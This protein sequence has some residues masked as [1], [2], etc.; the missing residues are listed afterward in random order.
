MLGSS[1]DGL[2]GS[3]KTEDLIIQLEDSAT[4]EVKDLIAD[5]SFS[6]DSVRKI[7]LSSNLMDAEME[8]KFSFSDLHEWVL[9]LLAKDNPELAAKF[10]L[11][12]KFGDDSVFFDLNASINDLEGLGNLFVPGLGDLKKTDVILSFDNQRDHLSLALDAPHFDYKKIATDSLSIK[13]VSSNG[14]SEINIQTDSINTGGNLVIAPSE[15]DFRLT[16]NRL[17]Y[18]LISQSVGEHLTEISVEGNAQLKDDHF[19][20]SLSGSKLKFVGEEWKVMNENQ[21]FIDRDYLV[22]ENFSL[23]T[24]GKYLTFNAKKSGKGYL[25]AL[26]LDMSILNVFWDYDKLN[27]SGP[28]NLVV[29][30]KDVL[31]LSNLKIDGTVDS[32]FIN[33]D[34][35]GLMKIT[36]RSGLEDSPILA[37]ID[38]TNDTSYL[39]ANGEIY[40]FRSKDKRGFNF[41]IEI[42]DYPLAIA[43]YWIGNSVSGT[44]GT[45]DA[46][47]VLYRRNGKANMEGTGLAKNGQVTID[48]LGTTYNMDDQI[49]LVKPNIFDFSRVKIY[50]EWGNR[51]RLSGGIRHY[52]L[53]NLYLDINLFTDRFAGLNTTELQNPDYYGRAFAGGDIYFSGPFDKP[54]IEINAI[55]LEGSELN[56]PVD[57]AYTPDE[58]SFV[59]FEDE[60][61]IEIDESEKK[62]ELNVDM[63]FSIHPEAVVRILFDEKAG[64]IMEGKG[65]GNIEFS[66]NRAGEISMKGRYNIESGRYTYTI[67]DFLFNKPFR[68]EP[69]GS[70]VWDGDPFLALIDVTAVYEGK[71]RIKPLALI[72]EYISTE[73]TIYPEA[74]ILTA[75]ELKLLLT[76]NL[77]EPNIDFFMDFPDLTGELKSLTDNKIRAMQLDKN[78]LYRQ[79]GFVILFGTFASTANQSASLGSAALSLGVN[80]LS[81]F[82]S[83][84]LSLLLEDYF[85]EI[86]DEVGFISGLDFDVYWDPAND[87]GEVDTGPTIRT[88]GEAGINLAPRFF[89]DRLELDIEGGYYTQSSGSGT[90]PL[91]G[92]FIITYKL[93][94]E[95]NLKVKLYSKSQ[96]VTTG[97]H[98]KF[99]GGISFQREFNTLR[100]LFGLALKDVVERKE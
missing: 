74:K 36:A 52:N 76:G 51:A 63:S 88:G 73:S 97:R 99:G 21:I 15:M 80:T 69:G 16:N 95:G 44:Q 43:D 62:S 68:V 40:N 84:Q 12:T 45:V 31:S 72:E 59:R 42:K 67:N 82:L 34:H 55:A 58:S 90:N 57:Y 98:N 2:S 66:V 56:L 38:I 53:K 86:I 48:Y 60:V 26:G 5:I 70:I 64:D 46:D 23:G 87:E 10:N 61:K 81:E 3:G 41:D 20:L 96:Q 50:D 17:I 13:V 71:K 8:G 18:N 92:N 79:A 6:Q 7:T 9:G 33:D 24:K 100:E 75:F 27:F 30:T 65:T 4:I 19:A 77:L 94:P 54:N 93:S 35:F 11:P 78:E 28:L 91:Y 22:T 14:N 49:I 25:E 32:L 83:N 29:E 85:S 89:D 1:L 37:T 47:L 39:K